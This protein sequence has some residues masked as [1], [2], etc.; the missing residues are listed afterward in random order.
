MFERRK[1]IRTGGVDACLAMDGFACGKDQQW[2]VFLFGYYVSLTYAII[3]CYLVVWI[4]CRNA[5]FR[6]FVS[7]C[8]L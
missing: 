8:Q 1:L 3:I 4:I 5:S 2:M 6:C 7:K